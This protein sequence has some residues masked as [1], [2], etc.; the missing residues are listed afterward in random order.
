[1]LFSVPICWSV[2]IF[3]RIQIRMH[4]LK[5]FCGIVSLQLTATFSRSFLSLLVFTLYKGNVTELCK[6][7]ESLRKLGSM[8]Q[9]SE[10]T[11]SEILAII[12]GWSTIH[13]IF[14]I[15]EFTHK[16]PQSLCFSRLNLLIC[17]PI[18]LPQYCYFTSPKPKTCNTI[19]KKN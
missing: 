15:H 7:L 12:L 19:Y 11:E 9:T 1:M 17:E 10:Q 3:I 2:T 16:H 6:T 14:K 5:T 18:H 4:Y 8:I 13:C